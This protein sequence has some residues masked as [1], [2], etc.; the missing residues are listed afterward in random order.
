[1]FKR[2]L[3]HPVDVEATEV[4]IYSPS[5]P[6]DTVEEF[7]R[8]GQILFSESLQRASEIDRK[9]TS[10]LGWSVAA[11]ASLLVKY[12]RT[13]QLGVTEKALILVAVISAFLAI[14]LASSAFKTRMWPS[15]SEQDWFREDLWNDA[16]KLRRYHV[17]SLLLTRHE[18]IKR[19]T[20]KA[21]ILRR[22]EVLL[23]AVG[24]LI[25]LLLIF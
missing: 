2:Q 13:P 7:Y 16:K 10:M 18:H 8:F 3:I 21:D 20:R 1:M 25:A 14:V 23:L 9:L 11:L 15:P 17:I 19:I 6:D 4:Q 12:S 24:V 22:V 5:T